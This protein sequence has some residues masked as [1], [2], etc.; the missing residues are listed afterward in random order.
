[1]I[2]INNVYSIKTNSHFVFNEYEK[3]YLEILKGLFM[4]IIGKLLRKT[5]ITDK[6]LKNRIFKKADVV[7]VSFP[8]TGRTWIRVMLVRYLQL[9]Y[10]LQLDPTIV[11]PMVLKIKH[12]KIQFNH[13]DGGNPLLKKTL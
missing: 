8:K 3:T 4:G 5:S 2:G 11:D 13:G 12:P 7:F 6:F 9:C 10:G 1:L